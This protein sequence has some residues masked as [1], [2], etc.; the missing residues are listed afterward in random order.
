MKIWSARSPFTVRSGAFGEKQIELLTN[1]ADQAV[2]A[3]ENARLLNEL[4]SPEIIG[5]ADR[6]VGGLRGHFNVARRVGA[7]V[8]AMLENAAR[9]CGAKSA[10][11]G[12][13]WCD[14]VISV[15]GISPDHC[16]I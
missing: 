6:D 15:R 14:G 5:A 12:R 4:R 10:S 3:I 9:I 13:G 11:F 2:I 16:R 8:S 7:G 1:F